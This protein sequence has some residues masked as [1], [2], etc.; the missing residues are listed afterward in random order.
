MSLKVVSA[1]LDV[2]KQW[3]DAAVWRPGLRDKVEARFDQTPEGLDQLG[4]WLIGH[5]VCRVGLEASGG[6]EVAAMDALQA[7]GLTVF[8]LNAQR[9]R[10]FAK[11]KGR[12]AKTDTVD[13][14]MIAQAVS[15]LPEDDQPAP[16]RRRDLDPLVERLTHRR[17]LRRWISDCDNQLEHLA[18]PQ[19]RAWTTAHRAQLKA[20]VARLDKD[21]AAMVAQ[22]G[23]LSELTDRLRTAKGVGPLLAQTLIALLP[24]LGQVSRRQIASLVGVAPFDDTSGKRIGERHIKGGREAIREVLYMATL[25][26]MRFNPTIKAFAER[27]AGKK[28]KVI[29]VA[30]MRKLLVSLNAMARDAADWRPPATA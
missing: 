13:A 4:G 26:A 10:Q 14:R 9:V 17:Q 5:A 29:I 23:P 25:T 20:R 3:I 6:Y 15:V 11:A 18:D 2:S 12:L 16:L 7:Q 1:G 21:L 28:P 24:E 30:C 22:V 8:R 27:L 19:L